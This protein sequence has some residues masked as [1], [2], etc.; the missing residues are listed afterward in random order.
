MSSIEQIQEA[1]SLK[2]ATVRPLN[3]H[4][5]KIQ[6][7]WTRH[8]GHCWRSKDELTCD[9]LL[10]TPSHGRANL[11]WAVVT[12]LQ[13]LCTDTGRSQGDLPGAMGDRD[14]WLERI[15]EIRAN[16]T[17]WWLYI[18]DF[19]WRWLC[20][21]AILYYIRSVILRTLYLQTYQYI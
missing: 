5:K 13:Q 10:W 9:V 7:R 6:I 14:E 18:Y 15:R 19:R 21:Y 3:T 20:V 4:L 1:T 11:G 8:A 17:L 16:G 2:T 12:Y